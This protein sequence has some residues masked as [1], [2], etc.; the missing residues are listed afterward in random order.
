M[1]ILWIVVSLGFVFSQPQIKYL[2]AVVFIRYGST[3]PKDFLPVMNWDSWEEKGYLELTAAGM[4]EQYLL[5]RELRRRYENY[6]LI[7]TN[8]TNES[9][10]QTIAHGHA[11]SSA[12]SFITGFFHPYN[13]S[14]DFDKKHLANPPI[15]L[16]LSLDYTLNNHSLPFGLRT[17]PIVTTHPSSRDI[18]D[19][20]FCPHA[21][22]DLN[23]SFIMN[24]KVRSLR[25]TN[26]ERFYKIIEE[27]YNITERDISFPNYLDLLEDILTIK[28]QYRSTFLNEN[29]ESFI[30][31]YT[32]K[33][34]PYAKMDH[35][36]AVLHRSWRILNYTKN[37]FDEIASNSTKI[38]RVAFIFLEDDMLLSVYSQLVKVN[39]NEFK[40]VPPSSILEMTLYTEGSDDDP[41][42]EMKYN[43]NSTNMTYN[44]ISIKTFNEFK[45]AVEDMEKEINF[46]P[47]YCRMSYNCAE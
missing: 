32:H 23:N 46:D 28:R 4:R 1:K 7:R 14:I 34:Y 22:L 37:F 29:D 44:G 40:V 25:D 3:T 11:R 30:E 16:N 26:E 12:Q 21:I 27:A 41:K 38:P 5:G 31:A 42:I 39:L 15:K 18:F 47:D 2:S 20:D 43:D 24:D 10:F 8:S 45:K 9:L 33:L 17:V 19:K 6:N 13:E 35:E 36:D